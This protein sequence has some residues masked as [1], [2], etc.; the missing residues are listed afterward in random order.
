MVLR[1]VLIKLKIMEKKY[2]VKDFL[3]NRYWSVDSEWDN[4]FE[5]RF[6]HSIQEAQGFIK[7]QDGQFV[8]ETIY[9]I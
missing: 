7:H 6:F 1:Y 2:V 4:Q 9:I 5:A 3:T 8:I